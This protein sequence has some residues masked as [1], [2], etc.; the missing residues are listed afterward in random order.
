[1]MGFWSKNPDTAMCA[2][3]YVNKNSETLAQTQLQRCQES[4]DWLSIHQVSA[5]KCT[6]INNN[7][8]SWLLIAAQQG[9]LDIV[10]ALIKAK[11]DINQA[12]NNGL[13][14][15]CIATQNGHAEVVKAL[16]NAAILKFKFVSENHF[17]TDDDTNI[18]SETK[19][20][21]RDFSHHFVS[22][23]PP[24]L[25]ER[26]ATVGGEETSEET[27]ALSAQ[28]RKAYETEGVSTKKTRKETRKTPVPN[29]F[30]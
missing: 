3:L 16:T 28:K 2:N 8:C 15:L 27:S 19:A 10:N 20:R 29:T 26:I 24:L 18:P 25:T 4:P 23:S 30:A 1:M 17:D 9:H 6:V 5:R 22:N 21:R 14:P 11:A 7:Q 13:T 12:N